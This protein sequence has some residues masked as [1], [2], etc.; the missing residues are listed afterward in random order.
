M[1]VPRNESVRSPVPGAFDPGR[2]YLRVRGHRPDGL[3][4]FDFAVGEPGVYV[5]LLMRATE[6]EEFRSR[7]NPLPFPCDP[8]PLPGT[9]DFEWRLHDVQADVRGQ[10]APARED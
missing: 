10:A 8:P 7:W 4:E 9:E 3:V 5:E 1:T 2:R 6:F